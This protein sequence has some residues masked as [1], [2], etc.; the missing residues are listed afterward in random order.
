MTIEISFTNLANIFTANNGEVA[1]SKL[2]IIPK[3]NV[4]ISDVMMDTMD[5]F[6]FFDN[7][8]ANPDFMAIPFIFL[9][10]KTT[11]EEK[12]KGLT[13]GSLDYIEKPFDMNELR[14]KIDSVIKNHNQQHMATIQQAIHS[15]TGQLSDI[16]SRQDKDWV[17]FENRCKEFKL[18]SRQIEIARC[19]AEGCEYKE[20]ASRLKIAV[21]TVDRH[22]QNLY[23]KTQVHNKIE[24][25]NLLFKN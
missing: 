5:G 16:N 23:E 11:R 17:L 7:I 2:K 1:L 4:I 19:I 6:E 21:K 18:T 8:A 14:A 13:K 9:T 24:L 25:I 20:I 22:I 12:L 10:A 15:L 3:P